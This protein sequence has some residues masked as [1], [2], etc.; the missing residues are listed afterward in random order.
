MTVERPRIHCLS[1]VFAAVVSV[2]RPGGTQA[3]SIK[4]ERLYLLF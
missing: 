3:T 4:P 2:T 1:N